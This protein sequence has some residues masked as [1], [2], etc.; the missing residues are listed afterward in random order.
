V[1][2]VEPI[3]LWLEGLQKERTF[4]YLDGLRA[5]LWSKEQEPEGSGNFHGLQPLR[6]RAV[7]HQ[8]ST[9][10]NRTQEHA[11][12]KEEMR[13]QALESFEPGS[14]SPLE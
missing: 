3:R 13:E 12:A 5:R 6:S 4:E 11:L 7:S 8:A 10:L 14:D 1:G 9:V 2:F